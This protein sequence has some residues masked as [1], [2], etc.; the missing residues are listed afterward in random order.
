MLRVETGLGVG[1]AILS[2]LAWKG[3]DLTN[4]HRLFQ[5]LVICLMVKIAYL[6]LPQTSC[7]H[8]SMCFWVKQ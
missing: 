8:G 4:V 5:L 6:F 2:W 3:M 7:R 1:G